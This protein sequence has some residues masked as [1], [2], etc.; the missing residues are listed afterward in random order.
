MLQEISLTDFEQSYIL[1]GVFFVKLDAF[2]FWF[3][4]WHTSLY[5]Y[6]FPIK[7]TIFLVC[8]KLW[9]SHKKTMENP[10][11]GNLNESK[12]LNN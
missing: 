6:S 4:R 1:I 12:L 5:Q 7:E 10:Q 9:F 11:S 3:N 8:P 2:L